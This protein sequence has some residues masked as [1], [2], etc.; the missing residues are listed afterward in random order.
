MR[1][2]KAKGERKRKI[3]SDR[4]RKDIEKDKGNGEVWKYVSRVYLQLF[5]F[6]TITLC[7][8]KEV[9]FDKCFDFFF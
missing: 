3:E 2:Q 5:I 1:K 7:I 9:V 4:V 6:F 8:I